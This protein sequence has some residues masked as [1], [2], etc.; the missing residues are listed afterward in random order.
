MSSVLDLIGGLAEALGPLFSSSPSRRLRRRASTSRFKLLI[1]LV[2]SG[3]GLYC[4]GLVTIVFYGMTPYPDKTNFLL[5][6]VFAPGVALFVYLSLLMAWEFLQ[7]VTQLVSGN[8]GQPPEED[9]TDE[10]NAARIAAA[11][12]RARAAHLARLRQTSAKP[13]TLDRSPAAN[14]ASTT[15]KPPPP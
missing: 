10:P 9:Q 7:T 13:S 11:R 15:R 14:E 12:E 3:F 1:L 8:Y 5:F 4:F 6:V 2:A